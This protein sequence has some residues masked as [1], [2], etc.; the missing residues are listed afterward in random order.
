MTTNMRYASAM[1][2]TA[3]PARPILKGPGFGAFP[4]IRRSA[5]KAIGGM[6]ETHSAIACSEII[7]LN[8]VDE[9]M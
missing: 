8:A 3:R 7:A 5:R 2:L 1:K 9:P 4:E 6:Y